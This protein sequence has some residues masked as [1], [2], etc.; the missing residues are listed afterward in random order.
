MHNMQASKNIMLFIVFGFYASMHAEGGTMSMNN[1]GIP[2][3]QP[4]PEK[5]PRNSTKNK[6]CSFVALFFLYLPLSQE[7]AGCLRSLSQAE[8]ASGGYL[9]SL[10][11]E[12]ASGGY[13]RSLS[14]ESA[15]GGCLRQESAS[16]GCL[17]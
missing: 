11:Q 5:K 15:S 12:S 1:E 2:A 4:Q 10:S 17:R 13:L 7:S 8:S 3:L 6:L 16:G 14:Q 9:R